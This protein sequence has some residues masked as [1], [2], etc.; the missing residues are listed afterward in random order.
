[1]ANPGEV[2]RSEVHGSKWVGL[3]AD[4]KWEGEMKKGKDKKKG[5][6]K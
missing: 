6:C 2:Y 4:D 5:G 1:M 3:V